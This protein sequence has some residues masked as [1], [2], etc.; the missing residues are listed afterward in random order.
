MEFVFITDYVAVRFHRPGFDAP[1]FC[2]INQRFQLA[3]LM[4]RAAPEI[5]FCFGM[6][7]LH[8]SLRSVVFF[9]PRPNI[10]CLRLT[11]FGC[12]AS[13]TDGDIQIKKRRNDENEQPHK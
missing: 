9:L 11:L 12:Q 6:K 8:N 1:D 5:F 13:E 2:P 10:S 3:C 7:N 4:K